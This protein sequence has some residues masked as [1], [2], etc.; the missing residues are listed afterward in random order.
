MHLR[1]ENL[2]VFRNSGIPLSSLLHIDTIPQP[3]SL[4]EYG[5][6]F[7]LVDH[8]SLLPTFRSST[9]SGGDPVMAVI[10]HHDD[11]HQHLSAPIREIT[12]PMGS[13]SSLVTKQ[14]L[15]KWTAA[16]SSPGGTQASPVPSELATLLLSAILIDTAGL[17]P[18]GKAT[19]VDAEAA[20]FLYP[21]STLAPPSNTGSDFT[22]S[23][24]AQS[25]SEISGWTAQLQETKFNISY[26]STHDLLLRDDKQYTLPTSSSSYPTLKVGLSTVPVGLKAWIERDGGWK[27]LMEGVQQSME[28]KG[29]DV[30]GVLT[31]FQNKNDKHRRELLLVVRSGGAFKDIEEAQRIMEELQI[32]LE[33][34]VLLDLKVWDKK[35]D[36]VA[37]LPQLD[38]FTRVGRVWKQ[39]NAKATRKQVAPLLVSAI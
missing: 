1:P 19:A 39:G 33:I 12:V 8:N 32:G 20:D 17:K 27:A 11:E 24:S 36:G 34:D 9:S 22:T 14:F 37:E 16:N 13:C 5:A 4:A 26:M 28:E 30:E 3:S 21:I 25:S 2:L 18:G 7:A 10:D 6:K 31:S 29:L 23:S 35:V 38:G 15:S